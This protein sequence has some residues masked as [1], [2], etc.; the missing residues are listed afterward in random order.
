MSGILDTPQQ[1]ANIIG[2]ATQ[3]VQDPRLSAPTL[4][5]LEMQ[6]CPNRSLE[7]GV[8]PGMAGLIL[9]DNETGTAS[10]AEKKANAT[11]AD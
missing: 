3:G 1:D 6:S 11:K 5:L 7:T 10:E 8:G 2:S 9:V 4:R